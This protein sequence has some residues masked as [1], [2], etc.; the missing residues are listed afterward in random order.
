MA[1]KNIEINH[2]ESIVKAYNIGVG[3]IK[4]NLFFTKSFDTVNHVVNEKESI[5][6]DDLIKVPIETLDS[7]VDNEGI[8]NLIKIDV[9]GFETEVL[10]GM[11]QTLKS[12][13]LKAIIIELNGS[14]ERYGYDE[15]L[16]HEKFIANDFQP[17]SYDPFNRELEL[18]KFFGSYNTIY[19][20]DL[21]FVKTRIQNSETIK[22]FSETF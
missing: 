6:K 18:L 9:E 8:P 2:L 11:S 17:Y 22:V 4:S 5:N 19:I 20:R 3:S 16:I 12:N 14:G 10:R 7:I 15:K 13:I 21:D 1:K